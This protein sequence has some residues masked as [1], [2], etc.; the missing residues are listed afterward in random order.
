MMKNLALFTT[1]FL[2]GTSAF[3]GIPAS[4]IEGN[5]VE[6]RTCDVYTAACFANSEVGLTG[7]EAILAWGVTKGEFNGTELAGLTVVAVVKADKTLGDTPN[8][9]LTTKTVLYLDDKASPSQKEALIGLAKEMAKDLINEIVLVESVPITL[10]VGTCT[11]DDCGTLTAGDTVAI[12]TRCLHSDDKRCGN[13]T[14]YYQPLTAVTMAMPHFTL[15]EKY[16]GKD[17]GVT[18]DD[19][20]RRGAFVGTF[21]R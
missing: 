4:T 10:S 7:G 21:A 14:P 13:D 15:F 16:S 2:V 17:L 3:A 18:W 20:G 8:K 12:E 6:A 9:E 5:Y 1:V 11:K 19:S